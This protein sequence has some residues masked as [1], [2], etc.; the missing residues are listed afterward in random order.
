MAKNR[1]WWRIEFMGN[2]PDEMGESDLENISKLITEGYNQGEVL[3]DDRE[4]TIS[5]I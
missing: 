5:I 1:G 2:R 3:P 4:D